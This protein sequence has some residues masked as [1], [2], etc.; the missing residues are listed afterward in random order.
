MMVVECKLIYPAL[1]V[2]MFSCVLAPV[3]WYYWIHQGSGN[4]NFYYAT[5]LLYNIPLLLIVGDVLRTYLVRR[6]LR[7]NPDVDPQELYQK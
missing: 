4:A 5:T 6:I 1:L 3:N 7:D 2:L